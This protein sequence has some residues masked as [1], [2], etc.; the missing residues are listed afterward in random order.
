MKKY[1]PFFLFFAMIACI[2]QLESDSANDAVPTV[3]PDR[4]HRFSFDST[5]LLISNFLMKT[6]L[7]KI[8]SSYALG[9]TFPAS[10]L[11]LQPNSKGILFW[12]CFKPGKN[13]EFFLASE[14]L[15]KYDMTNLPRMPLANTLLI[16]EFT[17]KKTDEVQ[18]VLSVKDFL[19]D[20]VTPGTG[21]R[22]I[23][24]ASVSMYINSFDS[25]MTA[26]ADEKGE[27]YNQYSF[28]FFAR[29]KAKE[30]ER[31]LEQ[32]GDDGFV[33]Y[34]FGYDENDKPNRIRV[35]LI[36]GD[37]FGKNKI[38]TRQKDEVLILQ[39]SWPPPVDEN[40]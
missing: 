12:F 14:Q 18:D 5:A 40:Q 7:N 32:A 34:Y 20:Q 39:K 2:S 37:S 26:I 33:K 27:K 35:I 4:S 8:A 29:N 11:K 19:K 31:F 24:N 10:Q 15:E 6:E 3:L 28:S 9:G 13:P 36:S 30:V 17:F 23:D 38:T 1:L 21:A 16:P 25:L 22:S